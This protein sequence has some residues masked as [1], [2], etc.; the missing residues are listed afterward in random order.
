MTTTL[1]VPP[2]ETP[3]AKIPVY[4]TPSETEGPPIREVEDGEAS[5][6]VMV[7]LGGNIPWYQLSFP[8]GT[9]GWVLGIYVDE[10]GET[11]DEDGEAEETTQ[12]VEV[13][14]VK[15]EQ[16]SLPN[17][18]NEDT[19]THL[20]PPLE[21]ALKRRT[22]SVPA[23]PATPSASEAAVEATPERVFRAALNLT[24]AFEGG[25]ASLNTYDA[26]IVSY[27]RFQF[28]LKSGSLN[29]VLQHYLMD[30]N[31]A[32]AEKLKVYAGRITAI[33]PSLR[34]E[35]TFHEWLIEAAKDP[36]MQR[37]QDKTAR[38]QYWD[39]VQ[40]LSVQPRNI[41]TPLGQALVFDMGINHGLYHD[42][43]NKAEDFFG[44]EPY[45]QPLPLPQVDEKTFIAKVADIRQERMHAFAKANNFGGL[46]V[47]VDFWVDL[48]ESGDWDLLGDAK[49]A[50]TPKRGVEVQVRNP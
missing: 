13:S 15:N 10:S 27:G 28:T 49:G 44:I 6:E 16:S 30:R 31:A 2:T 39:R 38:E 1:R 35:T 33:D 7:R 45:K 50:V 12:T 14:A 4:D 43:L 29:T 41:V 48:I 20:L 34:E 36:A 37:A 46:I 22:D 8:D 24:A 23:A 19:D 9:E 26:G 42:M 3:G 32:Y 11:V 5:F 21:E 18:T 25:Y 47:R 17:W 40:L